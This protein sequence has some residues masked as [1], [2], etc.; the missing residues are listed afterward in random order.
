MDCITRNE[1]RQISQELTKDV[2]PANSLGSRPLWV[3]PRLL[4]PCCCPKLRH[5]PLCEGSAPLWV[6]GRPTPQLPG[7]TWLPGG[8]ERRGIHHLGEAVSGVHL[9]PIPSS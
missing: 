2:L 9:V 6:E 8:T 3:L 4:G 7:P 5:Q 1:S